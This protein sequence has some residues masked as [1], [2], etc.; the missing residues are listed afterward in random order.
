V[1]PDVASMKNTCPKKNTQKTMQT[2]AGN[3]NSLLAIVPI[4]HEIIHVCFWLSGYDSLALGW[5][6]FCGCRNLPWKNG[7]SSVPGRACEKRLCF[8]QTHASA[9]CAS[10]VA[11]TNLYLDDH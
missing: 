8:R 3:K 10:M 1:L 11:G 4:S 5:L 2:T 6:A 9:L 7:S